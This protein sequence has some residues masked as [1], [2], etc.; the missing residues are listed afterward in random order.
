[1]AHR[2]IVVSSSGGIA[3][4]AP[5]ALDGF[6][7]VEQGSP[8]VANTTRMARIN[9]ANLSI[10]AVGAKGAAHS[11]VLGELVVDSLGGAEDVLIGYN[12]QTTADPSINSA[13]QVMVGDN[14]SI[15]SDGINSRWI[16]MLGSNIGL[17]G[18][19]SHKTFGTN[20]LI[21]SE[22]IS[23]GDAS[24]DAEN[25]VII[26]D[27]VR[28]FGG[29]NVCIGAAS[30]IFTGT[31]E[32]VVIG[33]SAQTG[34]AQTVS[35]GYEANGGAQ[36]V[37]IGDRSRSGSTGVAIGF[38][39]HAD[40]NGALALGAQAQATADGAIAIGVGAVNTTASECLIGSVSVPITTLRFGQGVYT[41]AGGMVFLLATTDVYGPANNVTG[42]GLQIRPGIGT[43]DWANTENL[44]LDFQVGIVGS[45]GSTQQVPTS[46]LA[47]RHSDLNVAL[48][49]G[50]GA[51][52]NGGAGVLFVKDRT[53]A[54]TGTT[55][56]GVIL[57]SEGG[58]LYCLNTVGTAVLLA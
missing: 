18:D 27:S 31:A 30:N 39:A 42:Y 11:F 38:S 49:G 16:T 1:M 24:G 51:A 41:D 36:G 22:I 37:A 55:T 5:F 34:G 13:N 40:G 9:D 54:P 8:P 29:S 17:T 3:P 47:I 44:G 52:F 6:L 35:V 28:V 45:N 20:V 4:G 53:T 46:A 10:T 32:S 57:Y 56:G 21:G 23:T 19:A 12:I 15:D 58:H 25:N 2:K 43:G 7:A 14:L 48:W 50:L 26:G 33:S